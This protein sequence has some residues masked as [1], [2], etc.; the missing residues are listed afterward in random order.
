VEAKGAIVHLTKA[1][2]A[3]RQLNAAIRMWF[4][5]EDDLAIHTVASAAYRIIRDLTQK[6]GRSALA[7][8]LSIGRFAC[9]KELVEGLLSID[10]VRNMAGP[11]AA[12]HVEEIA[13]LIRSGRVRSPDDVK[14]SLDPQ[15]EVQH[16]RHFNAHANFL[17][18]ADKD[19]GSYIIETDIDN[20]ILLTMTCSSYISLFNELSP[21][22]LMWRFYTAAISDEPITDEITRDIADIIRNCDPMLRRKHCYEKLP[23]V[24]KLHFFS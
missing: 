18:H 13:D 19:S 23:I 15:W 11:E 5:E 3:S 21:E 17:K 6:Q 10:H 4:A 14:V 9:A 20:E 16:W 2:A 12:K 1:A 22:M 8:G 7:D 24:K